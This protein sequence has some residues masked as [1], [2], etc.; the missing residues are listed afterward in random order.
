MGNKEKEKKTEIAKAPRE[1]EDGVR[2]PRKLPGPKMPSKKDIGDHDLSH[3]L[4]R[5]W[6]QYCVEGE[7]EMALRFKQQLREDGLPE[8]DLVYCFMSTEG[9]P[10]ATILVA[11][12]KSTKMA[13]VT[14][15][16]MKG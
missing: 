9:R 8:V 4:Y 5:S 13:M 7:G 12:E 3:L 14:V 1:Q 6:C 15:V 2:N 10:L 16:P 11:K